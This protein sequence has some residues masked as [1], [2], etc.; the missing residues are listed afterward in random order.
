M[1]LITGGTGFV[2][3]HLQAELTRRGV[4][5]HAFSSKQYDLTIREQAEAVF[6]AH[7]KASVI[8]HMACYQAAGEFPARHTAEQFHVNNLIHLNVLESWRKFAPQAKLIAVGSSCAYPSKPGALTED[9]FMDG[10]IHGSVYSYAFTK[11][12]LFTGMTAYNDQYKLNGTYLI[13]ATMY[14]EHDDFHPET[15]HVSGALVGRFV[16]AVKENQPSVEIWGDGTQVRDIMYVQDFI[17]ALLHLIP[18]CD[19][20]IINVGPGRGTSI[21]DLAFAISRAAG[22]GGEL[23]FNASRYVGVKEKFIETGKFVQK[24]QGS[25][26][27]ELA[28]GIQ[29]TVDWYAMNYNEIKDRRKFI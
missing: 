23:V 12:L 13:P 20:D 17:G 10:E 24:Y 22:Y 15:A 3:K 21:K 6:A 29:R 1:M 4:E 7:S 16:K 25:V 8:V 28:P 26:S 5:H 2:G 11:R 14:G 27:N 19:R 9:R 18:Q